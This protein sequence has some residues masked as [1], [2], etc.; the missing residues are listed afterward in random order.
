MVELLR[1]FNFLSV[2]CGS[3]H[4]D[5]LSEARRQNGRSKFIKQTLYV[6][7]MVG[8]TL[9][10]WGPGTKTPSGQLQLR[11]DQKLAFSHSIEQEQSW[12]SLGFKVFIEK[13]ATMLIRHDF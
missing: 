8:M 1:L 3:C 9:G 13:H 5:R 2:L 10:W 6:Q 12:I 11:A 4:C 7:R